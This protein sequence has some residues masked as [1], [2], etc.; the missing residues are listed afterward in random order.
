MDFKFILVCFVDISRC[1]CYFIGVSTW[2]CFYFEKNKAIMF[3]S[4][5]SAIMNVILNGI[6][7][8]KYGFVAAGYTTLICYFLYSVFHYYFMK[9]ICKE[10]NIPCVYKGWAFWICEIVFVALCLGCNMIYNYP[11]VRYLITLGLCMIVLGMGYNI[12]KNPEI[13]KKLKK[14]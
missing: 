8:K 5:V 1:L 11:R 4:I 14:L 7:I 3:A 2:K 9:K 13:I 6:F 12:I 10:E